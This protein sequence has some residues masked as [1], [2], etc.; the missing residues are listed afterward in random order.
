ML[1]H[2][3][4]QNDLTIIMEQIV[5]SVLA[6]CLTAFNIG[7]ANSGELPIKAHFDSSVFN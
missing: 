4:V 3:G 2:M 6:A 5:T 1:D 7:L